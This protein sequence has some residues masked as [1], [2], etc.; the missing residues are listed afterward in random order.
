MKYVYSLID[1]RTQLPFYIGMGSGKRCF[2]HLK[3]TKENTQNIRKFYKIQSIREAGFEPIVTIV[4]TELSRQ[5]ACE[6]EVE[7]IA[8]YGRK[9][10]DENGILMNL[11]PGGEGNPD[12]MRGKKHTDAAILKIK[13]ARHRQLPHNF[14]DAERKL[15]ST[16][17]KDHHL[18]MSDAQ[19]AEIA[20]KISKSLT[21]KQYRKG[22]LTSPEET[23][24]KRKE[25]MVGKKLH[26]IT[27]K[28]VSREEYDA[29]INSTTC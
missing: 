26:P 8:K 21:G 18:C 25:K 15:I 16:K 27:R 6:Y 28:W 9:D 7:L 19:R 3:E 2:S 29:Y 5:S 11:S 17:V 10:I 1:P 13:E 24:R 20:N 4:K 12:G 22:V 23:S 14:S